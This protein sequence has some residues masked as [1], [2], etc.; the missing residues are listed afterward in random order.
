MYIYVYICRF[1]YIYIYMGPGVEHSI[2]FGRSNETDETEWPHRCREQASDGVRYAGARS[3][4]GRRVTERY[5][6]KVIRSY[7]WVHVFF[8][9]QEHTKHPREMVVTPKASTSIFKA[10]GYGRGVGIGLGSVYE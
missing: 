5:A 2:V 4:V 1:I 6:T 10:K 7:R 9:L 8:L 3:G